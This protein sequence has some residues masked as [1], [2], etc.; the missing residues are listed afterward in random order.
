MRTK[1]KKYATAG[2]TFSAA[3][4]IGTVMQYGDALASRLGG[5]DAPQVMVQPPV[6]TATAAP[7]MILLPKAAPAPVVAIDPPAVTPPAPVLETPEAMPLPRIESVEPELVVESAPEEVVVPEEVIKVEIA[8]CSPKMDAQVLPIAMVQITLTD[9]C[10]PN[11]AVTIHHR[12]MMFQNLTDDDGALVVTVPALARNALFVADFGT[13]LGAAAST[14]VSDI[15]QYDRAVLQWQG[16]EDIELHALEFGASYF[17]DGHI[18]NGA[19]GD[20]A[21]AEFGTGGVLTPL[22][23]PAISDGFMAEVYTFPSGSNARDGNVALSVEAEVTAGNCGRQVAAQSL[24][25]V[26]GKP[27]DATDLVMSMPDCDAVGEFLV[28]NNMFEDLTLAAR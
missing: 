1:M 18:W 20:L 9:T 13:G 28:L 2:L 5:E 15:D 25:V 26:P 10:R 4:G 21:A 17:E 16:A 19:T 11:E 8:D 7:G 23:D 6:R 3:L 22:G 14:D 24:Q 27:T 12:G